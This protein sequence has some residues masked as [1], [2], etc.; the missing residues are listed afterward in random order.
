MV[1]MNQ[2]KLSAWKNIRNAGTVSLVAGW[3]SVVGVVILAAMGIFLI[4]INSPVS[5]ND[6]NDVPSSVFGIIILFFALLALVIAVLHI[7]GGT[8][9]RKPIANP[10]GWLIF[11]I[12]MGAL[13]IGNI[14]G[15]LT[16]IF[17]IIGLTS[18]SNIEGD[19]PPKNL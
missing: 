2:K 15:I 17:G 18:Y 1:A 12:V 13:G 3:L 6:G 7:V 14:I 5:S 9:L 11:L 16:L 19:K 10:K 4:I 8:K